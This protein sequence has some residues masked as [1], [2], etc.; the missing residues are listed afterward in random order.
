SA[1]TTAAELAG[2][3]DAQRRWLG[4]ERA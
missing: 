1:E 3:P 2:D 4:V